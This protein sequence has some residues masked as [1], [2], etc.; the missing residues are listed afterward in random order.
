ML[1]ASANYNVIIY[2]ADSEQINIAYN[3]IKLDLET[4]EKNGILRGNIKAE[5]QI[6]LI[7][8]EQ[9]IIIVFYFNI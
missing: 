3:K 2:D 4:M 7:K 5:K 6:E 1:F 9:I 8:G